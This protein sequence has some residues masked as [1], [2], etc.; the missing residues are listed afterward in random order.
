LNNGWSLGTGRH[1]KKAGI[2]R[3]VKINEYG[4]MEYK[5]INHS[6]LQDYLNNGWYKGKTS[7]Y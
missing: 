2:S 3:V 7:K 1:D 4:L 5:L 6:E